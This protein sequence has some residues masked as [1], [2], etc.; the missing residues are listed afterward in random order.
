M[1]ADL[2]NALALRW[3]GG[4]VTAYNELVQRHIG[5]LRG[6]LYSRCG[7]DADASDLCQEVFIEVCLKIANFDPA[8]SF[9]AWLYTI[10]RNKVADLFRKQKPLELFVP[11]QHSA[12]DDSHPAR[13]HEERDAAIHAWEK[14]FE[15]LPEAQATALWLRAQGQM[16]VEQIASTMDQTTANVKVLLFRARQRLARDWENL[17]AKS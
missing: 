15:I 2:D 11:E 3:K 14:I 4:D 1:A 12:E 7:R 13:I 9:T 5:S 16:S 10:A 8:Y 17:I 6:Y